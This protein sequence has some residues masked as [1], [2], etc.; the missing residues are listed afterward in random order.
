NLVACAG[1]RRSR[2][3]QVSKASHEVSAGAWA[4][5]KAVLRSRLKVDLGSRPDRKLARNWESKHRKM[6]SE[7][8]N[9][10]NFYRNIQN[11]GI[12]ASEATKNR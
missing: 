2:I 11:N 5:S 4:I 12:I 10:I 9:S 3:I 7:A 6:S 1:S 8:S